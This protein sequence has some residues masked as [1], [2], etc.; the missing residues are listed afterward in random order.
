MSRHNFGFNVFNY[1]PEDLLDYANEKNLN[2]IEINLTKAHS[3]VESFDEKRIEELKEKT[4]KNNIQLSFHLPYETNIADNI[5]Y[6]SRANI[7]YVCKAINLA[8]KLDAQNITSHM[9]FF[10][11]F[12][13]EKWQREKSLKRF[14]QNMTEILEKCNQCNV[15]IALE[16]VAPLPHGSE[17]LLLGDS[18]NDLD[19]IFTELKSESIKFCLDTGHAN[20]AEGVNEYLDRF[21]DKLAIIHYHDNNGK[22]DSHL[23]VGEGNINWKEFGEKL[24]EI[25]F[26]GPLI[27]ECRNLKP[28]QAAEGLRKYLL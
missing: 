3:S 23:P 4:T 21:V 12:P 26:Q 14:V 10:F 1:P 18:I 11:W 9:G 19:Y 5:Y 7:A 8:G 17:H 27:S 15:N 13:V 22:D 6:K 2:H 16:N 24:K 28:H 20:T 25:N